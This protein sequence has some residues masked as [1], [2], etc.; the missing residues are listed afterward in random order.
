VLAT[1]SSYPF[2]AKSEERD[3]A[4]ARSRFRAAHEA[5]LAADRVLIVGAVRPAWSWPARS[6]PSS[7]AST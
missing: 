4:S 5:L 3:I 2:P 1:G 7:P 6:R